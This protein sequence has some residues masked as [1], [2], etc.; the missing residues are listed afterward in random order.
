MS[1]EIEYDSI[2]DQE[3]EDEELGVSSV[4]YYCAQPVPGFTTKI[5]TCLS[6]FDEFQRDKNKKIQEGDENGS[7]IE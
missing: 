2:R 4:C 5:P 6:C 7:K 3:R 1:F